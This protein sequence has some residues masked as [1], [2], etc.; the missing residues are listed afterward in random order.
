MLI[1]KPLMLDDVHDDLLEFYL[2]LD[3]YMVVLYIL[4]QCFLILNLI[5]F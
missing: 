4:Y 2:Y 1:F 5:V 3:Y